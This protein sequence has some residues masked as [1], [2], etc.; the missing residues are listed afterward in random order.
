MRNNKNKVYL[1]IIAILFT[2]SCATIPKNFGPERIMPSSIL[3]I[4]PMNDTVDL[5][6]PDVVWP[7]VHNQII[8]RGYKSPSIA[9][10]KQVLLQHHIHYAGEI[11]MYTPEELGKMFDVDAVLYTTITDWATTWLIVYAS[12][13]V[14]LQFVLKSAKDGQLLW[15]NHYTDTERGVA[16]N[17]RQMAALAIGA[18][19]SP[20]TPMARRVVNIAFSRFPLSNYKNQQ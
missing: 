19:V 20:Y 12:Q 11:N 6:A 10:V 7:I 15:K 3:V 5:S 16:V 17:P 8:V 2:I 1:A 14:G 18:A 9:F 13:T 4:P